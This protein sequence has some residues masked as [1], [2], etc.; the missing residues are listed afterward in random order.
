MASAA[1]PDARYGAD[2]VYC[3]LCPPAPVVSD[4]G[5][6]L[7]DP[8]L[9][10]ADACPSA[11]TLADAA[12]GGRTLTF[13]ELCSTDLTTAVTLSSRAGVRPV[14]AIL[15]LAPNSVLYPL[16]FF[17]ITALGTVST[18]ANPDY[19]PREITK[20]VSDARAKLVITVSTLVPKIAGLRLPVILL[21]DDAKAAAS[22]L[23]PDAT[24]TLYTNLIAGVKET[25]Y[26]RPPIKQSDTAALLSTPPSRSG[27]APSSTGALPITPFDMSARHCQL[28]PRAQRI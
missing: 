19:T 27:V 8:L 26:R 15:I 23:P 28:A 16:C 4:L 1:V 21:D 11:L 2:G 18:T 22:S 20:Q 14:D 13:A 24:V 12:P 6:S 10:H 17:A 9:R 25:E 5:L 3:S 7:T